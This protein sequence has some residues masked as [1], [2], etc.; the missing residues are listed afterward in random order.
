[1]VRVVLDEELENKIRDEGWERYRANRRQGIKNKKVGRQSNWFTDINGLGGEVA[2]AQYFGVDHSWAEDTG[3]GG[4]D[5]VVDG[6]TVDVK[7]TDYRDGMLLGKY[8]KR[9]E[10]KADIYF[11]VTGELPVYRLRGWIEADE[12]FR[13]CN[14]L[15]LRDLTYALD[16]EA[17]RPVPS[18]SRVREATGSE[19]A[20][21]ATVETY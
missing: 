19:L 16:Q 14:L 10:P 8:E 21:R 13:D 1:M 11:M 15:K 2:F 6:V 18:Q 12:L 7:T 17:L 4:H 9:H 3:R 5:A 20:P